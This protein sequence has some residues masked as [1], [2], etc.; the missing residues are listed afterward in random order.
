M[1]TYDT[2][3]MFTKAKELVRSERGQDQKHAETMLFSLREQ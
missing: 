2:D 1:A 3:K